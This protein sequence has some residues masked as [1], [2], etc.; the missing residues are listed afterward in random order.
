MRETAGI[1][2]AGVWIAPNDH[3]CVR[4]EANCSGLWEPEGAAGLA[5]M[6]LRVAVR[7]VSANGRLGNGNPAFLDGCGRV[8]RG[9][10]D[11]WRFAGGHVFTKQEDLR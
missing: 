1:S 4:I 7:A 6:L 8:W 11:G 2:V 5:G 3:H 9:F 10:R